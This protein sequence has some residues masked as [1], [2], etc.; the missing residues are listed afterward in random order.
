MLV[1]ASLCG[2]WNVHDTGDWIF[3]LHFMFPLLIFDA[4]ESPNPSLLKV[5]YSHVRY[6]QKSTST[7]LSEA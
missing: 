5:D 2:W 6:T 7:C 3:R 4:S 1:A